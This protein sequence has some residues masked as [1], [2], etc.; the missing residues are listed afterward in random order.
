MT[1][2]NEP[3]AHG[4]AQVQT[5]S[6]YREPDIPLN[7]ENTS[8]KGKRVTLNE[9][10]KKYKLLHRKYVEGNHKIKSVIYT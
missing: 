4:R 9:E 7:R 1:S 6:Q 10:Q 2:D 3:R 8:K 5:T